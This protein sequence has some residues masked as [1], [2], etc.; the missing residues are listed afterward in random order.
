MLPWIECKSL[1]SRVL[2]LAA[3]RL[4]DDWHTRYAYRPVPPESFVEKPRFT[5]HGH[6]AANRQCLGDTQGRGKLDTFYRRG[7]PVKGV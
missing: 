3:P 4:P 6:K 1:A 2:A 5:G 7:R